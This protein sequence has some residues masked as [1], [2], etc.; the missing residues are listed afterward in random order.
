MTDS[1]ATLILHPDF[2][3]IKGHA[4]GV[5][6]PDFQLQEAVG[7]AQAIHL[8]VV[9]AEVITIRQLRPGSLFGSGIIERFK[10]YINS[11]DIQL[12]IIDAPLS[13]IQQRNL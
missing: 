13:P 2:K 3:H 6:D 1:Q 4:R 12:V 11:E 5:Y 10:G 7:L 9:D 8:N